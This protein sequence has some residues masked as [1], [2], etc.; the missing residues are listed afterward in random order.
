MLDWLE[1]N[2]AD[3]AQ[4]GRKFILTDHV[5]PGTRFFEE[6]M[7]HSDYTQRYFELLRSYAPQ[8]ALE[9]AGHEHITDIRYHSS[10]NV[11][12]LDDP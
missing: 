11:L 8:V 1:Q 4:S 3:G 12:D 9:V 10:H 5:Y 6:K 2:L 7:W